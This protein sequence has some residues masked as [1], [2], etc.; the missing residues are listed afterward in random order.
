MEDLNPE[1]VIEVHHHSVTIPGDQVKPI[2]DRLLEQEQQQQQVPAPHPIDLTIYNQIV[3]QQLWDAWKREQYS[4]P[5]FQPTPQP[6]RDQ[7]E[8]PSPDTSPLG[9]PPAPPSPPKDDYLPIIVPPGSFVEPVF[10]PP[11]F[12]AGPDTGPAVFEQ[13]EDT[14]PPTS[15]PPPLYVQEQGWSNFPFDRAAY[16]GSPQSSHII[17]PVSSFRRHQTPQCAK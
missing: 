16:V 2:I 1:Q 10:E 9:Y 5:I 7:V 4:T 17:V 3:N 13:N 11:A 8:P 14:P 6:L 12:F 15:P